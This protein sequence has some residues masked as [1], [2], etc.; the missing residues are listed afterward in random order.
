MKLRHLVV[1]LCSIA[2]LVG[3]VMSCSNTDTSITDQLNLDRPI[4]VAFACYGS[5]RLTGGGSATTDQDIVETAMPIQACDIRS[6]NIDSTSGLAPV[7][8]GQETIGTSAPASSFYY[9][10]ILQSE[11]GTVAIAQWDTKPSAN[12]A[13]GDVTVLDADPL[14]PGKNSIAMGEDPVGIVTDIEGCYEIT[15]NAGSC[16][17]SSLEINSALEIATDNADAVAKGEKVNV[18]RMNVVSA[19]GAPIRAK[20]RAIIA[21][22]AGGTIGNACPLTPQG[23]VYVAYPSC[24]LVAGIDLSSMDA[25]GNVSVVTSIQLDAAGNPTIGDGNISCPDEC[26]QGVVSDGTRPVA[27]SLEVDARSLRRT[28][29]IGSENSNIVPI[30]DLDLNDRPALTSIVTLQQNRKNNLGVTAVATSPTIGMGGATSM[31]NDDSALGGESQFMYAVASDTTV[32]VADIDNGLNKECD[33]QIDPR[34]L[35]GE[36][37][38]HTLSCMHVGDPLPPRRANAI[39]PGIQL[40]A[41]GVPTSIDTFRVD[42]IVGDT[43]DMGA[44]TRL[45]G[46]FGVITASN[47]MTYLLNIDNDDWFDTVDPN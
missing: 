5:L 3:A 31:I 20:A 30:I 23:L 22:P 18:Q 41:D 12:F 40:T 19:T 45:I 11:P 1:S 2:S 13:G 36:T 43:R 38:V 6:G 35:H 17:M 34:F 42:A 47:G 27:L 26:G 44:P 32:R 46:Y 25:N 10:F 24:H 7:P 28:L 39:G 16:D 33:T 15:A 9:G 4:D 21:E 14:L 29:V 37:N 8:P